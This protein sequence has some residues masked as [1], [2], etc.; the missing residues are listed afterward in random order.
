M[1]GNEKDDTL[2]EQDNALV[3][4]TISRLLDFQGR[5][6]EDK[7]ESAQ[8]A[9]T[10][11]E[12]YPA[13]VDTIAAEILEETQWEQF[14]RE[15]RSGHVIPLSGVRSTRQTTLKLLVP[16]LSVVLLVVLN[17]FHGVPSFAGNWLRLTTYRTMLG[18]L[19][20]SDV[21]VAHG[22]AS[23]AAR[24]NVKGIA[25]SS[26]NPSAVIGTTIVH[27]GDKILGATVSRINR[28]SVEFEMDGVKWKQRVQ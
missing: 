2:N 17:R 4:Q 21:P 28:E 23:Q 7:D 22:V 15:I 20:K 16:I 14:D 19:M 8:S 25:F 10:P 11:D 3:E 5:E 24:L 13:H 9:E 6:L 18:D 26:D 1:S 12:D 27:E